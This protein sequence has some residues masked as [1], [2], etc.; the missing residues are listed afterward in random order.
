MYFQ[1]CLREFSKTCFCFISY[2][3]YIKWFCF[4]ANSFFIWIQLHTKQ[5]LF[6]KYYFGISFALVLPTSLEFT[7]SQYVKARFPFKCENDI[8][9][10]N[11]FLLCLQDMI[12][13]IILV[14]FVI[15]T[16][17][18]KLHV[19]ENEVSIHVIVEEHYVRYIDEE[20]KYKKEIT[21]FYK[22]VFVSTHVQGPDRYYLAII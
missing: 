11:V 18:Y 5:S 8:I 13:L 6:L 1:V 14:E 15:L 9:W 2:Y 4:L 7:I 22:L 20:V 3:H 19:R 21:W 17:Q 12:I 16:K 10:P